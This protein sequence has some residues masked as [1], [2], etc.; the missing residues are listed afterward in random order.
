MEQPAKRP[1]SEWTLV[2]LMAK[3]REINAERKRLDVLVKE[4]KGHEDNIELAIA[5]K[6]M[7]VQQTAATTAYGTVKRTVKT[8]YVAS[9]KVAFRDWAITNNK[10]E[11]LSISVASSAIKEFMETSEELPPGVTTLEKW[12]LSWS[13]K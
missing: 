10:E 6:M 13:R 11:L 1:L 12:G 5:D 7:E 2:E 8:T 9:D 3:Y 4:Y